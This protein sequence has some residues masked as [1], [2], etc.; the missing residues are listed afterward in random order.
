MKPENMGN[1]ILNTML[2]YSKK[3]WERLS[4][5]SLQARQRKDVTVQAD[6]DAFHVR[7]ASYLF[8]K[9]KSSA[10]SCHCH[11]PHAMLC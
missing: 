3:S 7:R 8:T 2:I 11:A 4:S 5:V 1:L 10:D 9:G 6:F